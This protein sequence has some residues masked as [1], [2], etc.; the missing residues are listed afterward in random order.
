MCGIAGIID[1]SGKR[2][3]E[4]E[5]LKTL[6]IVRHRGPDDCGHWIHKNAGLGH[7]RLSIIGLGEAGNQP[8][9]YGHVEVVH[10][11]EIYNYPE[12]QIELA[13]KGYS[14]RTRT[15]TEVLAA[16][17][18][19]WGPDCVKHFNG[20]WAFA[21]YDGEQDHIFC[22][23]DRFGVKPF[24]FTEAG[25]K[26][27]FASEIKQFTA[28]AGWKA[29]MN[30]DR[31]GEWLRTGQYDRRAETLFDG[32]LQLKPGHNL[33]FD[34]RNNRYFQFRYYDLKEELEDLSHLS[35][36]KA[37]SGFRELFFDAVRLQ[38]R[39]DVKIGL[40]LSGGLDSSS[41]V[42]AVCRNTLKMESFS[43]CFPQPGYN[44]E[45]YID[46]VVQKFGLT[47]S[48]IYPEE[49]ELLN[50]WSEVTW[51][52]DEPLTNLSDLTHYLVFEAAH[53]KGIKVNLC[54]QGADEILA[55]YDAFYPPFWRDLMKRMPVRAFTEIASFLRHHPGTLWKRIQRQKER[56]RSP[57]DLVA[58]LSV[59]GATVLQNTSLR[60]IESTILPFILHSEDR[61]SMAFG[62]ESRVPFLDH[63]LVE[64]CLSLPDDFKIKNGI[65]KR[66][67]REALREELPEKVYRRYDKIGFETPVKNGIKED[68]QKY[69]MTLKESK[70]ISLIPK[71]DHFGL[72]RSTLLDTL[73]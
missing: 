20:I 69:A 54:G 5:L 50:K 1:R 36:E 49:A 7:R 8:M 31:C 51:Y 2:V 17:Y 25:N 21:I 47:P 6:E 38:M 3:D 13:Q 42:A 32:V 4:H 26:F 56:S 45:P 18:C 67:L 15:D 60:F 23:R 24:Y 72:W 14:F 39:S 53:K 73:M 64:F 40:T 65:R 37:T 30:E 16:A 41:L 66:L 71:N 57:D 55:G 22:S 62:I 59:A 48:K 46:A 19:H 58:S 10:N 35:F 68:L 52:M 63:R 70:P 29:Q 44:E 27:C 33:I 34:L 61:L 11:G 12:L 9:K 43:A 28:I